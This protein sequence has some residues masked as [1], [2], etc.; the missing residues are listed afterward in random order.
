MH[1]RGTKKKEPAVKK[2][3]R[4]KGARFVVRVPDHSQIGWGWVI[5][6]L[7]GN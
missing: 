4:R 6:Q 2:I 3:L 1:R 5:G 7:R